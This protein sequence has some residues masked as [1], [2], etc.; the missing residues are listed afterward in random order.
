VVV[1]LGALGQAFAQGISPDSTRIVEDVLGVPQRVRAITAPYVPFWTALVVAAVLWACHL[2]RSSGARRREWIPLAIALVLVGAAGINDVLLTAGLIQSSFLFQCSFLFTSAALDAV[3]AT[4][5]ARAAQRQREEVA[6]RTA[7]LAEKNQILAETLAA[8]ESSSRA[9]TDFLANMSHEIRTPMTGILGMTELVLEHEERPIERERLQMVHTSAQAMMR[10]LNDLLDLARMDGGKVAFEEVDFDMRELVEEVIGVTAPSIARPPIELS[11]DVA[12]NVP[13]RAIGDR[14]R[15]RQVLLNLVDNAVKFTEQGE[16]CARVERLPASPGQ[17]V[18]RVEVQDSG[19]G[20]P[21]EQRERIFEP[22][23]QA[24]ATRARRHPGSG[25][26][27]AICRQLVGAMGGEI[28]VDAGLGGGSIFHF[29]VRLRGAGAQSARP[30]P[31]GLV[32]FPVLVADPSPGSARAIE[33]MLV[34][35]RTR[36]EVVGTTRE[37]L[38]ALDKARRQDRP[39]PLVLVDERLRVEGL[40]RARLRELG[41]STVCVMLGSDTTSQAL[42]QV[43]DE[44]DGSLVKPVRRRELL[45]VV[46]RATMATPAPTERQL[47]PAPQRPLRLLVAEDH[48]V[49]RRLLVALLERAGHEV[50]A[51]HNGILAVDS[52][53]PGRFDLV[54]MDVRMP[55]MDGMEAT[56]LLRAREGAGR[57]TPVVAITALTSTA[58]QAR[59]AAAGM[60]GLVVKPVRPAELFAEI[61]RLVPEPTLRRDLPVVD[62]E[63]LRRRVGNDDALLRDLVALFLEDLPGLRERA[64]DAH[65]RGDHPA[66]E[67]AAHRLKGAAANL[68]AEAVREVL[69]ELEQAARVASPAAEAG[70]GALDVE[71]ERLIPALRALVEVGPSEARTVDRG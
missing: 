52:F 48:A 29:T 64:H 66:L 34:N 6:R 40:D 23:V 15:L 31:T 33:R 67:G 8:A 47:T 55:G 65:R 39:F 18:L 25:L 7:E 53:A 21:P 68:G 3:M 20:V 54:L 62:I 61:A 19:P 27:L 36:V 2:L 71:L 56:R 28:G 24:D 1:L 38:D 42:A 5:S 10:L 4:R 70:L 49:N 17:V 58:D 22:F 35:W 59:F 14:L 69:Q 32:G 11:M 13:T 46:A 41:V 45:D 44:V 63:G 37:A 16:V 51:V 30:E 50:F 57:H 43:R 12:P 60:D 9:R 26:G